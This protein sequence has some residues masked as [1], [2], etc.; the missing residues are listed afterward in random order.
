MATG[1]SFRSLSYSYRI[2]ES[3]I[4]RI[5]KRVLKVL[6]QELVPLLMK[7]LEENDFTVVETCFWHKW[8]IPNCVGGIDGKHVRIKAPKNSGSL[9]FNYKDYFSV[10]LLA[11][12][13]ANYK[14]IAVD[15]GAYGKESDNGIFQKSRMGNDIANERFHIPPPKNLPG[16]NVTLPHFLIGDEAFSLS[17]F[18]MK[19]YPRRTARL[20]RDK[21]IYNYRLCR[22]RRVTENAFGLLSQ[23]F[24]VFYSPIGISTEVVDDLILTA[25][26]LH[27]LLRDGY[28]EENSIPHYQTN[29]DNLPD[30]NM[31]D[32][33]AS[34][35]FSNSNGF[36]VRDKLKDFFVT[37]NGSVSWQEAAI[38]RI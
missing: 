2:S 29:S 37:E 26:C 17:S 20:S 19:P 34:G 24:R 7:P 10:V 36:E 27:N 25:C 6:R 35:G 12:V 9:F 3:Y 5:V 38:S 4:S 23:V 11:I 32:L 31:I 13:D 8:N 22:A 33:V 15:V 28:L 30:Q 18:M 21:E 16:T 14:F 1:E